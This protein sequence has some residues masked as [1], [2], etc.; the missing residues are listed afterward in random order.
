MTVA[1]QAY[2]DLLGGR[3]IEIGGENTKTV[4]RQA[5][6]YGPANAAGCARDE[7]HIIHEV[8]APNPKRRENEHKT[9]AL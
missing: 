4:A 2:D 8:S 9:C 6:R 3:E 1:F 7:A 5:S